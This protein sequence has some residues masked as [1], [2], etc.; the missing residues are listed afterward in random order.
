MA[1]PLP[2]AGSIINLALKMIGVLGVGQS[3]QAEDVNDAMTVM[4]MMLAQWQRKRWLVYALDDVSMTSTGSEVYTLGA[5]GTWAIPRP[6]KIE[7]AFV[8]LLYPASAQQV[9]YQ[10]DLL[11]SREDYNRIALKGLSTFPQIAF[12]DAAYPVGNLYLWPWPASSQFEIHL[13]IKTQLSSFSD[14]T[15]TMTLPPEYQ[16]ALLYNLAAR[17]RIAYGLPPDPPTNALA[18]VALNTIRNANAQVPRLQI[19]KSI[20]RNGLYNIYSDQTY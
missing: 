15:D 10:L 16:E 3:A 11:E 1:N 19:P 4:N 18:L 13:S 5:T 20:T 17:L 2:T 12:Y 6:D 7:A 9:D 14:L 8:R